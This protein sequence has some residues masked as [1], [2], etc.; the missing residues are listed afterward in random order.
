MPRIPTRI[1][2]LLALSFGAGAC[3]LVRQSP[4]VVEEAADAGE[5]A[6]APQEPD[7]SAP[8]EGIRLWA[9]EPG[10]HQEPRRAPRSSSPHDPL[11]DVGLHPGQPDL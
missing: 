8:S 1:L 10:L 11:Q 3:Q 2:L 7:V 6:E 4:P 5:E 9:P